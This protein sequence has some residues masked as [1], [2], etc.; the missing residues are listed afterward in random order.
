M[1]FIFMLTRQD[2]TIEDCVEVMCDV[3][4]VGLQHVGFKD[5]GVD[6]ATL[7]TLLSRIKTCGAVSYMEV[8]STSPE[9][10]LASARLARDL[11][12]D[13]LLGGTQIDEIRQI[14]DGSATHYYPFPGRPVGHPTRLGGSADLIEAHCRHFV[15]RGCAG[16]DLLAFRASEADPIELI[17]AAR[18][19]L[20]DRPLIVAGSINSR[21]RIH[22]IRAAGATAFTM[23]SAVFDG[24]YAPSKGGLRA[25]LR[26][27]LDDCAGC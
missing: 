19:G 1:D 10:S 24:S 27:V 5:I 14:L 7:A 20:G 22:A 18:R 4:T 21:D 26:C 2:R 16:V 12:V 3:E 11:G 25:R 23:G 8:V 9:A 13:R 6:P 15:D 17:R